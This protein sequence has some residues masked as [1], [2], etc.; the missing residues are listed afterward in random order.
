LPIHAFG[1]QALNE[2][3]YLTEEVQSLALKSVNL[4]VKVSLT[5]ND[6]IIA[7]QLRADAAVFQSAIIGGIDR[8]KLNETVGVKVAHSRPK[9][10]CRLSER[11]DESSSPTSGIFKRPASVFSRDTNEPSGIVWFI[12]IVSALFYKCIDTEELPD[13]ERDGGIS[14]KLG[15]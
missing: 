13:K 14:E 10:G 15:F 1:G 12:R 9:L 2:T 4:Y 6:T 7:Y 3:G 5:K 11:P 8:P